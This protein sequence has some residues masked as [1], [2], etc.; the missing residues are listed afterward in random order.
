[1]LSGFLPSQFSAIGIFDWLMVGV[2]LTIGSSVA[3]VIF[4]PLENSLSS[5]GASL[6]KG[7]M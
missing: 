5:T 4:Q 6:T 1:M 3:M 2:G 7:R